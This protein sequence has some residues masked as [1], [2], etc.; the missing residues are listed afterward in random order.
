MDLCRM[1]LADGEQLD[2]ADKMR[3]LYGASEEANLILGGGGN[4]G[5][6]SN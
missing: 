3:N 5:L 2:F 4:N 6:V 1:G